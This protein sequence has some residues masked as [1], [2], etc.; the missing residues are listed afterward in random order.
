MTF[1]TCLLLLIFSCAICRLV[2]KVSPLSILHLK[3]HPI[4]EFNLH[5][6][7]VQ[8]SDLMYLTWL[9]FRPRRLESPDRAPF[10]L[11]TVHQH[12]VPALLHCVLQ[13]H[14]ILRK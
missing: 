12:Q 5:F 9:H 2:L 4:Q 3:G 1:S 13:R 11:C 6:Y 14:V 10:H 8:V 7:S